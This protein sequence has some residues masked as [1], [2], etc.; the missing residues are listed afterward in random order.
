MLGTAA[1]AIS[2]VDPGG[3]SRRL[4]PAG[5]RSEILFITSSCRSCRTLWTEVRPGSP[6]VIVTPSPSTES[7]RRVA[8]LCPPGVDVI[9]SSQAWLDYRVGPAPWRVVA[10]DGVVTA[11]GRA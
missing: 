10:T 6:V 8:D 11:E 2:G 5:R 7:R 4:D 1:P 3:G 9:M